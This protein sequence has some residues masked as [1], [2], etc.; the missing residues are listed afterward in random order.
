MFGDCDYGLPWG[1]GAAQSPLLSHS[2]NALAFYCR[3]FWHLLL[4]VII[5]STI[6]VP[7]AMWSASIHPHCLF[8]HLGGE[9][10]GLHFT[11]GLGS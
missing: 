10:Y 9:H 7:G 11:V 8:S 4:F 1:V 6:C 5:A 2:Y 3:T